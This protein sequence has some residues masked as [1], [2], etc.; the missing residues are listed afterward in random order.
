MI[1]IQFLCFTQ[2]L[3]SCNGPSVPQ[4]PLSSASLMRPIAVRTI[5][6]MVVSILLPVLSSQSH[7]QLQKDN[8]KETWHIHCFDFK[9]HAA[10]QIRADPI[11]LFG[12]K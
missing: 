8:A 3:A 10:L 6:W 11:P 4:A 2:A 5:L 1:T 9:S 12:G 7:P